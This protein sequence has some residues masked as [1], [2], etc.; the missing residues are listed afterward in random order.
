MSVIE[1]TPRIETRR[2]VLRAPGERDVERVAALAGDIEV[3]RMTSNIPHPYSRADAEAFIVRV[4]A[5]DPHE[6]AVF[7]LELE[8]EGTVG[9][10]SLHGRGQLGPELGYWIGRPWWGRGLASE[11]AAAVMAWVARDWGR[12]MA[13]AFHFRDNP[14]S[15]RVLVKAGFL[16]T[17]VVRRQCSLARKAGVDAQMMVWLA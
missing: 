8:D 17:G 10:I 9:M 3:S 1:Q 14:A 12:R 4:Q 11:A 7:V 5:L 6:E 2:L 16:Y 15:G 13:C